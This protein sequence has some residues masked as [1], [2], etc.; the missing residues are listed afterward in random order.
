MAVRG[1]LG[2]F[3]ILGSFTKRRNR[4]H[5]TGR[6]GIRRKHFAVSC[7]A[8]GAPNHEMP[9]NGMVESSSNAQI[10]SEDPFFARCDLATLV[11]D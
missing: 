3:E 6:R 9:D 4:E 8:S 7:R 10:C 1:G 2:P 5:L 11:L